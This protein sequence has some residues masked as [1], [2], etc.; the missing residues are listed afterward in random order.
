MKIS[1]RRA[2]P[3]YSLAEIYRRY[4]K[5]IAAVAEYRKA[6]QF[7]AMNPFYRYKLGDALW[8]IGL[9]EESV[10]QLEMAVHIA[11]TDGFYHFW[12]GDL[13]RSVRQVGRCD[14]RDAAGHDLQSLRFVLHF[15]SWPALFARRIPR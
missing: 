2:E 13:V 12:L 15:S 10:I 14:Y 5:W 11:P 7:N 8:H 4:G 1:P 9:R 6:A 3:H